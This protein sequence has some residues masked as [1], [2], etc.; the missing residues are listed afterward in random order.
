MTFTEF[1]SQTLEEY[2]NGYVRKYFNNESAVVKFDTQFTGLCADYVNILFPK[3]MYNEM[4]LV[5][6]KSG[7]VII[8]GEVTLF[9]FNFLT[10]NNLEFITITDNSKIVHVSE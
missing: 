3:G 10:Q 6:V 1:M 7:A 5:T 8:D 4:E 9:D 2:S